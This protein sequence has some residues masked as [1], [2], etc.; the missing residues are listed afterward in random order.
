MTVL[1]KEL[2]K[3]LHSLILLSKKIVEEKDDRAYA[4]LLM[5]LA[6]ALGLFIALNADIHDRKEMAIKAANIMATSIKKYAEQLK[7]AELD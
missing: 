7:E 4:C 6:D 3:N 1:L 2:A 5:S